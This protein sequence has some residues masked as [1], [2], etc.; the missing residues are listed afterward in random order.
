MNPCEKWLQAMGLDLETLSD[1]SKVKLQAKFDAEQKPAVEPEPIKAADPA[2]D[3]RAAAAAEC[4]PPQCLVSCPI[5]H[6]YPV[7]PSPC[8]ALGSS[9]VLSCLCL[10]STISF[11][12]L[13][14]A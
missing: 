10:L 13:L 14:P 11:S 4:M 7:L 3:I 5:L 12:V 9:P 2:A 1:E 6:V 8:P